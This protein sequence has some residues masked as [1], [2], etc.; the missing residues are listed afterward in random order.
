MCVPCHPH[1]FRAPP[2]R[3]GPSAVQATITCHKFSRPTSGLFGADGGPS[4][5]ERWLHRCPAVVPAVLQLQGL[6]GAGPSLCSNG[7]A[8]VALG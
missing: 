3:P 4:L 7:R 8:I 2:S 5:L 1:P 6:A